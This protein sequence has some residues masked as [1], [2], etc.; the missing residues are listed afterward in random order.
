MNLQY[1][2][3]EVQIAVNS[4][5]GSGYKNETIDLIC[6]FAKI[7]KHEFVMGD[8]CI[9]KQA[10]DN[11]I[12]SVQK[13]KQGYP[14]QYIIGQWDFYGEP[15][16]VGEGV[17]I[18]RSD[19]EVLVEVALEYAKEHKNK[20]P[21]KILDIC[22]GTGCIAI[23]LKRIINNCEV[24]AIEKSDSAI[25]YLMQNINLH[26]CDMTVLKQDALQDSLEEN[27]FDIIVSNPPYLTKEDM[28][29]LQKEVKFEPEMA[30]YGQEN[31][32]IFYEVLAHKYKSKLKQGGLIAFEIGK[33]QE[34]DVCEILEKNGYNNICKRHDLCDIIRVIYAAK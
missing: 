15:F 31:G 18:P 2:I 14:L 29:C 21:L 30:L 23:T 34:N 24:F 33:N 16:I 5:L 19:T 20:S 11:I 28:E 32:L 9:S 4:I 25:E 3:K 1:S 6:H 27:D 10:Y 26:N 8:R 22:S 17:L 12:N 7:S 13:R